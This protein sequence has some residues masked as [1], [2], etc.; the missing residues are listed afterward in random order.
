MIKVT[1]QRRKDIPT[2][3]V[4]VDGYISQNW[5]PELRLDIS[6]QGVAADFYLF[7]AVKDGSPYLS[8][9][10]EEYSQVI[11]KQLAVYMD[12]AV[13]GELRYGYF[14]GLAKQMTRSIARAHWRQR[15]QS[16]GIG[17][18]KQG[19][20]LFYQKSWGWGDWWSQVGADCSALDHPLGYRD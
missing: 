13:G 14:A 3:K 9:R 6:L 18:L 17:L 20:D 11:A 15:R 1:L 2:P 16:Q 19:R 12:A 5:W 7:Y 10:F 4:L 8:A